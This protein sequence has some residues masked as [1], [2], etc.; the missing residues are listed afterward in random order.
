MRSG[1]FGQL[2]F[3][4]CIVVAN[5]FGEIRVVFGGNQ[6]TDGLTRA[7]RCQPGTFFRRDNALCDGVGDLQRQDNRAKT[8]PERT[9][10]A[11]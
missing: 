9:N 11:S 8:V 1:R 4:A 2:D 6:R 3:D 10:F 7:A 5:A